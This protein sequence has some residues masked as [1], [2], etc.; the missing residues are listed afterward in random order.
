MLKQRLDHAVT[1]DIAMRTI[2]MN[3]AY[4]FDRTSTSGN[5]HLVFYA[6]IG[7]MAHNRP[8][9]GTVEVCTT[10]GLKLPLVQPTQPL[11]PSY[12]PPNYDHVSR[13]SASMGHA[14][15]SSRQFR[16][17]FALGHTDMERREFLGDELLGCAVALY[18]YNLDKMAGRDSL[19]P[20]PLYRSVEGGILM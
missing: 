9:P 6:F 16:I 13:V 17:A 3:A 10:I 5:L 14:W 15:T 1:T 8:I 2:A 4:A 11:P 12:A 19:D 18:V 7:W 20:Q